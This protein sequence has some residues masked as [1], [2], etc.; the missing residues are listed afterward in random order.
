MLTLAEMERIIKEGGSVMLSPVSK[1]D[2]SGAV[3]EVVQGTHVNT[4]ASLHAAYGK[5][6]EHADASSKAEYAAALKR[7]KADLEAQLS[8]VEDAPGVNVDS[9]EAPRAIGK[10]PANRGV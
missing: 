2:K 1:K 10:Q 7:Q 5:R 6:V 4:L 9:A 3:T 8:L